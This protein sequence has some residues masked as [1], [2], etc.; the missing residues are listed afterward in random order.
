MLEHETL[1]QKT[2]LMVIAPVSAFPSIEVA[3]HSVPRRIVPLVVTSGFAL[4]LL[5]R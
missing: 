1:R 5:S 2:A 4:D 3:A